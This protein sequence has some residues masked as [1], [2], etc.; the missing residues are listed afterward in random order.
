MKRRLVITVCPREAGTIALAV[1]RGGPRE[2]MDAAG[3]ARRL[4][5]LIAERGLADRIR[6][7]HGCAGG[8]AGAGPNV[9]VAFYAMP[10][11]GEQP[12]NVAIGW[13]TYVASLDTLDCVARMIDDNLSDPEIMANAAGP[14]RAPR[15]PGERRGAARTPRP[16]A[17]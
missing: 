7:Q 4:E 17:R 2:R 9:S 6:V 3:I 11:P 14:P 5:A 10:A 8:C 12:D 1:T 16:R 15:P 13:K